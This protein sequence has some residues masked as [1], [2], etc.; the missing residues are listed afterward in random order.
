M[1]RFLLLALSLVL[2]VCG[3]STAFAETPS[4]AGQYY[5]YSYYVEGRGDYT[6]YFHFY[7]ADPVLGAVFYAGL[8]NNRVNYAGLYTVEEKPYEYACYVDRTAQAAE[9]KV[10]TEGTAPYTVHFMNWA[11]EEIDT[12]GWDGKILYND[13]KTI[14]GSGSGPAFYHLDAEGKYQATYDEEAGVPYLDFVCVDDP[15]CTVSLGHNMT[16]ADMMVYFIDGGWK[17]SYDEAKNAVYTLTPFDEA[18]LP[19]TLTVA[20]DQKTAVYTDGEGVTY[21]MVNTANGEPVVLYEGVGTAHVAAYGKDA[22]LTLK[23]LDDNSCYVEMGLFGN[24]AQIDQ[25]TYTMNADYSISFAFEKA[26][27]LVAKLDSELKA[28]VLP[29]AN[30][31]TPVGAIEAKLPIVKAEKEA[32]VLLSLNGSYTR[33]DLLDDGTFVFSFENAGLT[34][35][36]TWSFEHYE[37]TLTKSNGESIKAD[38]DANHALSFEYVAVASDQVRDTF[39]CEAAV[40]GV[41]L[42]K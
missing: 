17:L 15:T 4:L 22:D 38:K 13:C 34:E 32:A 37:L 27:N 12:C 39:A 26:G 33:I 9:V 7:D 36:G 18:E 1:K 42:V 31:A 16:Y 40:W 30:A 5:T 29:Y 10:L 6:F 11:G 41:A 3:V 20:P 14:S 28:V 21:E 35:T 8:S 19:A 2:V 24:I 23:L 25:G